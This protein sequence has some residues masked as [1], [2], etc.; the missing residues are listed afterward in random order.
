MVHRV[1]DQAQAP[2]LILVQVLAQ[3]RGLVQ[4]RV[5]LQAL[6]T[7]KAR[8]VCRIIRLAAR[9]SSLMGIVLFGAV[10]LVFRLPFGP[11]QRRK[12]VLLS[13]LHRTLQEVWRSQP[14]QQ[15]TVPRYLGSPCLT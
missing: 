11:A 13:Q 9:L 1:L 8:A 14:P 2:V 6:R 4:A 3:A 10:T 12:Q 5:V 7:L 15:V